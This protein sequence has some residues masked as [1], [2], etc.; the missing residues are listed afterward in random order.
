MEPKED[1]YEV[2]MTNGD[3]LVLDIDVAKMDFK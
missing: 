3:Q 1:K 2:I